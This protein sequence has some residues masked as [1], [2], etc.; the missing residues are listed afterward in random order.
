MVK[1]IIVISLG[2]SII[3]P[4]KINTRILREFRKVILKNTRKYKFIIVCGGGKTARNYIK[5]LENE[6]LKQREFFQCLLGISATK[7]NARFMTYFF[8]RDANQGIPHDMKDIENLLRIH[9]IVF[10]GALRY[11]KNETSDSVAAKLSRHFNTDFINLTD[12]AGLYDK[13]PKRY[14]NAKFIPDISHK[15][16]YKITKKIKFKPGQHFVLDAK[17]AK[18]IKKYKITTY[19]LGQDMKNLN[20]LLN[21]RHFIGTVISR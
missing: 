10:C 6:Q 19:L 7:L 15:E 4:D 13:N 9:D 3:I 17:A 2:G 1:K 14:R 18:I 5:G 16:F 21:D 20:N 12:T 11:A 8:G